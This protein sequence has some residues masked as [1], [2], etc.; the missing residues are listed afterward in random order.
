ML[1]FQKPKPRLKELFD[2]SYV[3]IH[4]HLLFGIDDGAT[5][6][7]DTLFLTTGL[8]QIG[9]GAFI[10]TPHTMEGVWDNTRDTI[11]QK[12]AQ[13]N[14]LLQKEGGPEL[15]PATEYMLDNGF[16]RLLKD[17]APLLTLKKQWVLV[18]MSYLNPPLGLYD[19][20]F[21]LQNA[22]YTPVLAHPE[23]YLFYHGDLTQ[24]KKLKKA[25]C[26]FQL[27]LLSVVGYYGEGVL[28]IAQRLLKDNMIDFCGSDLHHQKHLRSFDNAVLLKPQEFGIFKECLINN[29]RFQ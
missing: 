19:M 14:L 24:Y 20:L 2:G 9:F 5:S 15:R 17:G 4:S 26:L 7:E 25:G 13:T 28:R 27:N 11:L 21:D 10:T 22:G 18:E 3:D 12:A 23:R 29:K 1:F 6:F 16:A 8:E